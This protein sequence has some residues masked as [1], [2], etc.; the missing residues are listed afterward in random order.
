MTTTETGVFRVLLEIDIGDTPPSD[1]FAAWDRMAATAGR[2][3][4][5]LAQSLN[6]HTREPG[7][8]FVVSEWDTPEDFRA[9][10]A[11]EAHE[12]LAKALKALG[13]TVSMTGM[14]QVRTSPPADPEERP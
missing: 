10:S 1:F 13:R 12:E 6:A 4:G 8:Y 7:R 9:F 11:G 2:A 3:P 5:I 14:R